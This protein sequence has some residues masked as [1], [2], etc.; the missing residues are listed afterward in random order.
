[1][2]PAI[3]I[4]DPKTWALNLCSAVSRAAAK[5]QGTA[6]FPGDLRL[7]P[8]DL[9]EIRDALAG[10]R[11]LLFH[12]SR[13]VPHEVDDIHRS[14]LKRLNAELIEAKVR[15]ALAKGYLT[16]SEAHDLHAHHAPLDGS[17]GHRAGQVCAIA[18]QRQFDDNPHGVLPLLTQWGGEALYWSHQQHSPLTPTLER[19]GTP[20]IVALEAPAI[21]CGDSWFPDLEALLVATALG[22]TDVGADVYLRSDVPA[23]DI[24][25]VWSPGTPEYDVHPFL[26]R[27]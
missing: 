13:L 6:A 19:L 10:V 18:S 7:D 1:M 12:A 22:A 21:R 24:R 27:A 11:V 26:P 2:Q 20:A 15:A 3:E 25:G 9:S 16:A 4:D 17:T 5:L 14:G 23:A 8:W